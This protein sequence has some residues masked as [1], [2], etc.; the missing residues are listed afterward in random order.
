MT[1]MTLVVSFKLN[2]GAIVAVEK[3]PTRVKIFSKDGVKQIKGIEELEQGC[4]HIPMAVDANDNLY[5]ASRE[6]GIVKCVAVN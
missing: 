1:S 2:T 4:S 3:D 5:L 6:K